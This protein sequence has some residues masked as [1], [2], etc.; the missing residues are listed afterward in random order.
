MSNVLIY[1]LE[2]LYSGQS[3]YAYAAPDIEEAYRCILFLV[4]DDDAADFPRAK[5]EAER[6]GFTGISFSGFELLPA[7]V[8]ETNALRGF[9]DY[10]KEAIE[11][12]S[13]L[14]YYPNAE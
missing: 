3:E 10:Y 5:A 4:Q 8:L 6:Y 9:T 11:N 13:S 14:A 12:G 2:G 1:K 7:D